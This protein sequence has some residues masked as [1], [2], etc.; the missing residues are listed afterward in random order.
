M[1]SIHS[2]E[3]KT[4]HNYKYRDVRW[5]QKKKNMSVETNTNIKKLRVNQWIKKEPQDKRKL[6]WMK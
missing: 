1:I 2:Y 5:M 4:E 6:G 3:C